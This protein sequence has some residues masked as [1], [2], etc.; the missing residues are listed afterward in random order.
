MNHGENPMAECECL[1]GCPFFNDRMKGL[2]A[3]KESMK[4]RYCLGDNVKCAR[5]MVFKSLGKEK[6]PADLV[7]N[8]VERAVEII[9]AG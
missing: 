7:P 9:Q 6:V 1:P 5:Y 2:E 8:Q 4:K 3:I